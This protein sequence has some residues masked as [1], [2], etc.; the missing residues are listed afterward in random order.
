MK[1]WVPVI[2]PPCRRADDLNNR[3]MVQQ[4]L[5]IHLEK[6]LKGERK[7]RK[8]TRKSLENETMSII[9]VGAEDENH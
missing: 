5:Y 6:K 1:N 4:G 3:F 7:E 8:R 2:K 9:K